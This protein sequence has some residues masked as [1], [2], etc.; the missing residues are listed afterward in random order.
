MH[1]L[2]IDLVVDHFLERGRV[3][4]G[5]APYGGELGQRLFGER[6]VLALLIRSDELREMLVLEGLLVETY[7]A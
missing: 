5:V 6:K 3:D 7:R 4:V 2:E 1:T